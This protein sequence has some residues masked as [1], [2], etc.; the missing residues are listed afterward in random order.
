[1]REGIRRTVRR[2]IGGDEQRIMS[3]RT[4]WEDLKFKYILLPVWVASFRYRDKVYRFLVNA[5]TGEVQG[6]RPYSAWKITFLVLA[7]LAV[8][9]TIV[10]VAKSQG[11]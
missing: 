2:D 10:I 1:M 4:Q 11:S 7:I 9:A 6:E 5:R 8:I 3:M